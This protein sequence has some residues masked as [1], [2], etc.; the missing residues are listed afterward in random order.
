MSIHYD[1]ATIPLADHLFAHLKIRSEDVIVDDGK[2]RRKGSNRQLAWTGVDYAEAMLVA[3]LR[4]HE[5]RFLDLF[6]AYFDGVLAARDSEVGLVDA[7][8]GRAVP[9]W[10]ERSEL[11]GEWRAHATR[12]CRI[13]LPATE[14]VR[15]VRARPELAR[16]EDVTMGFLASAIEA[17]A[18]FDSNYRTRPG[19]KGHGWYL[20]PDGKAEPTNHAHCIGET[21]LNLFDLT[22]DPVYRQRADAILSVFLMGVKRTDEGSVYWRYHPYFSKLRPLEPCERI[23]KYAITVPFVARAHRM[24][25][26]VPGELVAAIGATVERYLAADPPRIDVLPSSTLV[27]PTIRR[28]T[29]LPRIVDFLCLADTRP[30]IPERLRALMIRRPDLFDGGWFGSSKSAKACA[31]FLTATRPASHPPARGAVSLE[32]APAAGGG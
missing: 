16:Y 7:V 10:G 22:R 32:S 3:F 4:T 24:G 30:S 1:F 6:V 25:L 23:W 19:Q 21:L 18:V 29:S 9:A 26:D 20:K 31:A 8:R 2:R 27:G 15:I 12:T 17:V 28:H 11:D 5:A 13:V 14:F